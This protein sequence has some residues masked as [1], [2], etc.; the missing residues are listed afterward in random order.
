MQN[1]YRLDTGRTGVQCNCKKR[2]LSVFRMLKGL[3][4][5]NEK[6]EKNNRSFFWLCTSLHRDDR[7]DEEDKIIRK[8][9]TWKRGNFNI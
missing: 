6:T 1:D 9:P 5:G 3:I 8:N 7:G 4:K 2:G